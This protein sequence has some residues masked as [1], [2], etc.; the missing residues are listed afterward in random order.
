MN[1]DVI[2]YFLELI[3]IDSESRDE[4]AMIDRLKADLA[5]LGATVTEDDSQLSTQGNAGNL[6]ALIPGKIDKKPILFCAHADTVKPGKGIKATQKEG[7]IRSDGTTVL[8]GDD[9]SGVAE[10]VMGIREIVASEEDHAPVEVLITVSEEIGL[11]G[12]KHFD[13][14]QLR[15]A[16]GYALDAHRVGDLVVGAPA[17]NSIKI[18][19][20]GK[21]AHAGVEPEKGINAIR[22]A[23]E[24][25]AAMP[26]GRIDHETTC[27]IGIISGGTATNIVPNRVEIKGEARSHNAP[28]LEQLTQDIRHALESTIQRHQYDFGAAA[29]TWEAKQEYQSFFLKDS[30]PAVQLALDAL[31]DAGIEARL[32]VG[33]GGSDANIIN[34]TGLPMVI[35][36][37]GMNKVHTVGEDIEAEE[38]RRGAAFIAALIRRYSQ[39]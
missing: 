20:T 17:Q 6:H 7:I 15:S 3:A 28:K 8:G 30:E 16:L 11:L 26:L 39:K 24:A 13:K 23:A 32:M 4:R 12:A 2:Q 5:A 38:L 25:I 27:N 14:S 19:V 33:G 18:V 10:I 21:E 1:T 37:T 31:R 36:G 9:K 22:V 29:F 34:A 35:C